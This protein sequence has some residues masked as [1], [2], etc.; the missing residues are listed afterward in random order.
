[1]QKSQCG[2]HQRLEPFLFYHYFLPLFSLLFPR[3]LDHAVGNA[4]HLLETIDYLANATGF[5][6]FAEFTA[7]DIGTVDSGLNSMVLASNNERVIMPVSEW[8]T[9]P[10]CAISLFLYYFYAIQASGVSKGRIEV[11][12]RSGAFCRSILSTAHTVESR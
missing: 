1:M 12:R 11:S 9:V 8:R 2:G 4:P 3:R 10:V 5:H 7:E 6:E